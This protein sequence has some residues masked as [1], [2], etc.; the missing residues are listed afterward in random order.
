MDNVNLGMDPICIGKVDYSKAGKNCK[1]LLGDINGDG[2]MEM[3]FVQAKGGIDARYVPY[4]ISCITAFALTGEMLW[5]FGEPV[6]DCGGFGADFPA[7]VCDID[8]DGKLEVLCV[9]EGRFKVLDGATGTVKREFELPDEEAHDCILVC[10]LSGNRLPQDVILKDRY[11]RM[12]A[13]DKDFNLLWTHE[14]NVGHFP[15]ASDVNGD[16]YDEI[17]AGYD[18]LNH[19]GKLL[20]SCKNLDDHADC[21]WVGDVNGDGKPEIAVGG[22]STC[23]YDAD[24]NELWR[25][26]DSIE[27]Q[28]IALGKFLPDEPGLQLAGLDRIQRGDGHNGQ[29]L[30][31]MLAE[32]KDVKLNSS[33][34]EEKPVEGK[35]PMFGSEGKDGMFLLDNCGKEVWKEDRQTG[36]WLTIVNTLRN[37]NGEGK[38]YILAYRRGGGV[39]PTL[40]DGNQKP[41]VSFTKDGYVVSADLFGRNKEEVIIYADNEAWIFSGTA[42]DLSEK[43]S[44]VQLEQPKKLYTSTL[45]PGGEY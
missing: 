19:E 35:R 20:W 27:S 13:M 29:H 12:W 4:E 22:S 10:N 34:R 40:Y 38:D 43:P 18:L 11:K 28:H 17:M 44:G 24:G 2:R 6:E 16:G 9:K 23:L 15:W 5:Q 14:G 21:L 3:I 31:K 42:Y 30:K 37:W 1:L 33:K 8:A 36:G 41:V 7:Q 25:Y 32:G 45:Y 39:M 26:D